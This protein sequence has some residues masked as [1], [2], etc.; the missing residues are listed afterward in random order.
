MKKSKLALLLAGVLSLPLVVTLVVEV[1]L[2]NLKSLQ[3]HHKQK[4]LQLLS[5]LVKMPTILILDIEKVL[6]PKL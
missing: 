4:K 5:K 1:A 2:K 6:I 3:L